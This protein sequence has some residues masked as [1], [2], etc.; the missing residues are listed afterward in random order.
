[1]RMLR[2][3]TGLNIRVSERDEVLCSTSPTKRRRVEED[4]R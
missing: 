4:V 2:T 3:D 1:M